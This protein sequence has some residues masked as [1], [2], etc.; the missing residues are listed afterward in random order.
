MADTIGF[1]F[2]RSYYEAA[3]ALPSKEDQ[4][5]FLLALCDYALNGTAIPSDLG[6]VTGMLRL[7]KPNI[8][9]SNK[10]AAAGRRG[11]RAS[12]E[13]RR[14]DSGTKNQQKR[15]GSEANVKQNEAKP[16]QNEANVNQPEANPNE[17]ER[18]AN[19]NEQDIGY[20]I[21][22]IG[23]YKN[24]HT[25]LKIEKQFEAFWKEYPRKVGKGKAKESFEK[26]I[27]SGV[28][29]E[30]L[31]SAVKQQRESIQ[32]QKGGGQFVPHPAT[33]LNQQRWEDEVDNVGGAD[34]TGTNTNGT[35]RTGSPQG[36]TE[37][38]WN[39]RSDL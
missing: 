33:W 4:A 12:G 22:D 25:P 35:G 17:T 30:V 6:G 14:N 13:A 32:W 9:K 18:T 5:D 37:K 36:K 28:T 24:P 7:V 34:G 27:K 2:F 20:R 26:A 21:K 39:L 38:T 16:K 1:T 15:N 3:C 11:G 19:E 31:I 29:L 10:K 23:V 8:D